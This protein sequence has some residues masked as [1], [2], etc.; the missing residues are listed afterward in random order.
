MKAD[1][2]QGMQNLDP[3]T[4]EPCDTNTCGANFAGTCAA[5]EDRQPDGTICDGGACTTVT[6]CKPKPCAKFTCQAGFTS[7]HTVPTK[8]L[9][10]TENAKLCPLTFEKIM[11]ASMCEQAFAS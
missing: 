1:K 7:K 6:C 11:D 5:G 9:L 3:V 4:G 8:W 2:A 10:T